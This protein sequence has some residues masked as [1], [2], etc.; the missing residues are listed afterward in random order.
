VGELHLVYIDTDRVE[1]I[2]LEVSSSPIIYLSDV[3]I[4]R[5]LPYLDILR[6]ESHLFPDLAQESITEALS[7]IKSTTREIIHT[8]LFLIMH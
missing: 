6:F 1:V 4:L 2:S 5:C 7:P 8:S 3:D